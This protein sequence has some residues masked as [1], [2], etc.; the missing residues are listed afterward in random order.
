MALLVGVAS[1]ASADDKSDKVRKYGKPPTRPC[2]HP[3]ALG[4]TNPTPK[5]L[6]Q[7]RMMAGARGGDGRN[8]R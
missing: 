8:G 5:T 4:Q 6:N 3:L 7:L 1:A 2:F